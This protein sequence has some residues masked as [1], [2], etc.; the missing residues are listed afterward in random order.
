MVSSAQD[1]QDHHLALFLSLSHTH[2]LTHAVP[3]AQDL[4]DHNVVLTT[5]ATLA[6]EHSRG[7]SVL[8]Q[9]SPEPILTV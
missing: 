4:Q 3:S 5:Y 9:V 1:L 2:T 8:H 6:S 7:R